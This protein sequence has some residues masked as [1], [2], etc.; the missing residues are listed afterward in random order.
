MG[1]KSA[2]DLEW[3]SVKGKHAFKMAFVVNE[4]QA[5]EQINNRYN[6]LYEPGKKMKDAQSS[7]DTLANVVTE[8]NRERGK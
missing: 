6:V 7:K 5:N 4:W 3:Q 8:P 1:E 2:H